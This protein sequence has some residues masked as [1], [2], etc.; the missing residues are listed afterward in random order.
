[1]NILFGHKAE[2][3]GYPFNRKIHSGNSDNLVDELVQQQIVRK[4]ERCKEKK[5]G[6]KLKQTQTLKVADRKEG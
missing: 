3:T 5:Y 1:M 6:I 4:N 2:R